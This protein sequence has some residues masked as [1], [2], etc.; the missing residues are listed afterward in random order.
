MDAAG[1]ETTVMRAAENEK[2]TKKSRL[3]IE[4]EQ[5]LMKGKR[6]EKSD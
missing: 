3:V 2:P 6:K 4:K 5:F 1:S